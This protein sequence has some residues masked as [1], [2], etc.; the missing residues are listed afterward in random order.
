M[1]FDKYGISIKSSK[2]EKGKIS[3]SSYRLTTICSDKNPGN[4][5]DI[6]NEIKKRDSSYEYYSILAREEL[7]NNSIHYYWLLIP[8]NTKVF[9]IKL[10]N[11]RPK[12]GKFGKNK[13][14]QVG[15]ETDN[16]SIVFSMSSQLWFNFNFESIKNI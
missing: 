6:V 13:D 2:I 11:I 15:W 4:P 1:Q 3:I 9:E 8:K 7:E 12:I 14:N 5:E 16:S 10:S